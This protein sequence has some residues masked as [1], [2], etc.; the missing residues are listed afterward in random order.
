MKL[1]SE[2]DVMLMVL[3]FYSILYRMVMD[4]L[5]CGARQGRGEIFFRVSKRFFMFNCCSDFLFFCFAGL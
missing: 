5:C 2:R 3:F 1:K 4:T